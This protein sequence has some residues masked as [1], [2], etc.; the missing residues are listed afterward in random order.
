MV[1]L[2]TYAVPMR[3]RCGVCRRPSQ[4]TLLT[5]GVTLVRT[6]GGSRGC[7]SRTDAW[8]V[9]M[10]LPPPSSSALHLKPSGV[11]FATH[12]PDECPHHAHEWLSRMGIVRISRRRGPV[13]AS[14][15]RGLAPP[16]AKE[17]FWL[18]NATHLVAFCDTSPTSPPSINA[19]YINSLAYVQSGGQNR[20]KV[21][22]SL[23]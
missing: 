5:L 9:R 2:H 18:H 17:S 8:V 10:R 22:D 19:S 16:L 20:R 21:G 6:H 11:T 4:A 15:A 7:G 3:C 14:V 12:S 1:L 23:A 13:R